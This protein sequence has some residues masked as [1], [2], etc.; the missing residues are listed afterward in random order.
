MLRE[1]VKA[2]DISNEELLHKFKLRSFDD[3]L[4]FMVFSKYMK[5]LDPS[6]NCLQQKAM[7]NEL[8]NKDG[9]V[10]IP[11]L[12]ENLTGEKH[13]TV[14][15]RNS[16]F[17]KI[18]GHLKGDT[19]ITKKFEAVD[20][21][22]IAKMAATENE[23]TGQEYQV[24]GFPTLFFKHKG[25]KSPEKYEGGRELKDLEKYIKDNSKAYKEHVAAGK[26][27]L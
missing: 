17:R 3:P 26:E 21:L 27:E 2:N 5:I 22:V 18:Q 11:F 4:T 12:L 23:P 13:E 9:K 10:E 1:V 24:Q 8:K 6:V 14:D 16:I 15:F 19:T 25:K 20:N 7:F